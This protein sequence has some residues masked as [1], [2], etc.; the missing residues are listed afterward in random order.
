MTAPR[1][2]TRFKGFELD[3]RAACTVAVFGYWCRVA[4]VCAMWHA[5]CLCSDRHAAQKPAGDD[6][7]GELVVSHVQP[8]TAPLT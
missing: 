5:S 1:R 4:L 6:A 7:P 3:S 8:Y 2:L